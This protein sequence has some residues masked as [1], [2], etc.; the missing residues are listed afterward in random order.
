MWGCPSLVPG[1]FSLQVQETTPILPA[2][3]ESPQSVGTSSARF[4]LPC[5]HLSDLPL[6]PVVQA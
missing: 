4:C 1:R 3:M 2:G 6:V 5:A